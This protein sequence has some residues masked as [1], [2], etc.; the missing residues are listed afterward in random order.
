MVSLV[1]GCIPDRI[2]CNADLTRRGRGGR[3]DEGA[4]QTTT[5]RHA[6]EVGNELGLNH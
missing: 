3:G 2:D 6:S 4:G 1:L 5:G